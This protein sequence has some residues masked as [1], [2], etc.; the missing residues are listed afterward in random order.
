MQQGKYGQMKQTACLLLL[1]L[2]WLPL[3]GEEVAK[4]PILDAVNTEEIHKAMGKEVYV[5]GTIREAF[6]VHG[7]VLMLTFREEKEGFIAVS[8]KQHRKVL[9]E[10]FDGDITKALKGKTVRIQG[11]IEQ[12]KYRPQIVI[13]DPAQIEVVNQ[14]D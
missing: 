13:K 10:A 7:N 3:P 6:W 14:A 8:F 11:V 2:T 9:D 12:Y 4:P 5:D 1:M